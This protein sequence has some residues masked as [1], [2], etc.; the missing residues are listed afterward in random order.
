MDLPSRA[1]CSACARMSPKRPPCTPS[2]LV[3]TLWDTG[4]SIMAGR[5]RFYGALPEEHIPFQCSPYQDCG[6]PQWF[7]LLLAYILLLCSVHAC[8]LSLGDM[9]N[10]ATRWVFVVC[11]FVALYRIGVHVFEIGRKSM[12]SLVPFRRIALEVFWSAS[13][14][15]KTLQH[16]SSWCAGTA[17]KDETWVYYY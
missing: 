1:A 14:H 11:V 16:E 5:F 3:G 8:W 4:S 2:R 17:L 6:A 12:A 15:T 7:R 10:C 13:Q 9:P